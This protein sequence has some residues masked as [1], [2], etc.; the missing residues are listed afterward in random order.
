[1]NG[2][3]IPIR[4][5]TEAYV[6]AWRDLAERAIEPNPLFEADCIIPAARYLPNGDQISLVIAEEESRFFG[7][8][9]VIRVAGNART[10]GSW[11][12]IRRPALKNVVSRLPF[13]CTPLVSE[14]RGVEAA[15]A[16]LSAL[17]D[18]SRARDAGILVLERLDADGPVSSYIESAA[19]GLRLPIYTY[20]SWSRPVVRRR[21]E[22]TYR[23][24]HGSDTLRKL[25]QKRRRLGEQLGG[26]VQLV[27]RSADASAIEALLA[28]EAAGWKGNVDAAAR[29]GGGALVLH[30]GEPEWLREMC[31]RFRAAGRLVLYS[32]Q[33][34]DAI[35]AMQL[36]LRGGEGM[37]DLM[38]V[39]DQDYARYSPGNQLI[40]DAIDRFHAAT[41]A[42]WLD[43][44]AG[45]NDPT[46]LRMY[47][48]R[49]TVST[50]VLAVGGSIDRLCF[51]LSAPVFLA[52]GA[53]SVLRRRHRHV[54]GTLDWVM[55]KV[56]L[57]PQ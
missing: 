10:S 6:G 53:D 7:C 43:T 19:K 1:V 35:L 46:A 8:F 41:D 24:I 38:M 32:L 16:L 34:G 9:P 12:G 37:F 52:L 3:I 2:R 31:D 39:F 17:T 36:M 51:R 48:D 42:Q 56:K 23:S 15:T 22:L 21:A 27:D 28:I 55:S 29:S 11:P 5:V 49:R 18:R 50:V 33:V 57:L 13:D 14:E 4:Q 25:A 20:L 44:C 26:E 47:P 45:E 30:A 54:I 40:L